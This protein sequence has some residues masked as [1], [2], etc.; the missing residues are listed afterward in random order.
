MLRA[1][2]PHPHATTPPTAGAYKLVELKGA[3]LEGKHPSSLWLGAPDCVY[4]TGEHTASG[5]LPWDFGVLDREQ[6]GSYNRPAPFEVRTRSITAPTFGVLDL[7][8]GGA[9]YWHFQLELVSKLLVLLSAVVE[10]E[11]EGLGEGFEWDAAKLCVPHQL[12]PI[13]HLLRDSNL[14]TRTAARL[15]S[16]S[17]LVTYRWAPGTRYTFKRLFLL[18][19]APALRAGAADAAKHERLPLKNTRQR[20]RLLNTPTYELHFPRRSALMLQRALMR[21]AAAAAADERRLRPRLLYYTRSDGQAKRVVKGERRLLERLRDRFGQ[22]RIAVYASGATLDPVRSV[23]QFA[24]ADAVLGPHGA[25]LANLVFCEPGTPVLVYQTVDARSAEY[26]EQLGKQALQAVEGREGAL[27]DS[28]AS[29]AGGVSNGLSAYDSYLSYLTAALGLPLTLLPFAKAHFYGNYSVTS[30]AADQT[31]AEVE[32]V[33]RATGRW[34]PKGDAPAGIRSSPPPARTPAQDVDAAQAARP[35]RP[36]R[37]PR[38]P[39]APDV[40]PPPPAPP[41]PPQYIAGAPRPR[42]MSLEEVKR[43]RLSLP[44][45]DRLGVSRRRPA[46]R[47]AGD[48]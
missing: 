22:K 43:H 7:R 6:N 2:V 30:E 5:F 35:P 10:L 23:R 45:G 25:S 31:V 28:L 26:R 21:A 24:M 37:S 12:L 41:P 48:S 13:L 32:T 17:G 8:G 40:P 29:D 14:F 16:D 11:W 9:A 46:A 27:A 4:F 36:P 15:L 42:Q 20:W 44:G 34:P 1:A 19:S 47:V 3:S 18:E 38:S 33:L 39:A